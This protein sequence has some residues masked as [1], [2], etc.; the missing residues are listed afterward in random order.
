MSFWFHCLD[1][2]TNKK[3]DKFC[4]RMGKAEFIKFFVGILVQTMTPKGHSEINW[5]LT[6][7][8]IANDFLRPF[9]TFF[10]NYMYIFHKTE[11]QTVILRC[12]TSLIS[13]KSALEKKLSELLCTRLYKNCKIW[14]W[15]HFFFPLPKVQCDATTTCSG[16]GSCTND[17]DC[18]CDN[19]FYTADCSGILS[20]NDPIIKIFFGF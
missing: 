7:E 13:L 5:P 8:K 15:C 17:G 16:H 9:Y 20:F 3:F 18:K 12:F 1:Q 14:H 6:H 4:P 11:V 19:G 2:N 10:A